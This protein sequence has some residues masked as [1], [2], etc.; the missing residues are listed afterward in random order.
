MHL[1]MHSA[2]N[3]LTASSA[4]HTFSTSFVNAVYVREDRFLSFSISQREPRRTIVPMVSKHLDSSDCP[5]NPLSR[6]TEPRDEFLTKL[7]WLMFS[8][9]MIVTFLLGS[10][11]LIDFKDTSRILGPYLISLYV[12]IGATYA[13]TLIYAFLCRRIKNLVPF[14]YVQIILDLVY[15]TLIVYITGGIDSIF[16]FLYIL[17][18]INASILLYR[19]GG[20]LIASLSSVCYGACI[21]LEYWGILPSLAG[22]SGRVASYQVRD[23]IYMVFI[24]VLAFYATALLSSF[25]AEQLRRSREELK[26]REVDIKELE[27]LHHNIVQSIGS[28]ILTQNQK[29]E[30]TSFNI[31]AQEITGY[32]ARDVLGFRFDEVFPAAA[33]LGDRLQDR[34]YCGPLSR[35]EINFSKPDGT[36]LFLG[37]STSVLRGKTG[38]EMGKILTFRDL[39]AFREMEDRMKRMDRL[40]AVGQLAA[41][42]AHEIRNPLTS[43]S[44]SIQVL[45]DE[46]HLNDENRRLMEIALSET[47]RL[48]GLITD[49]LLFAHPEQGERKSVDAS[50][51]VKETLAL[52]ANSPECRNGLRI[53][54]SI[55][56]SLFVLGDKSQLKQAFWNILRNAAQAQ[57][58]SG[59]IHVDL[60]QALERDDCPPGATG[61][62]V[63]VAFQDGG[64]GIPDDIQKKIFDPFFTTKENGSGLGLAITFRII[65][66][67]QGE[68]GIRSEP[69]H[70]TEVFLFLP[71]FPGH[72]SDTSFDPAGTNSFAPAHSSRRHKAA[73][74]AKENL[75]NAEK[76][77]EAGTR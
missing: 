77:K 69:H 32:E 3:I 55:T 38:N 25:L 4:P 6:S 36:R 64:D 72:A 27:A 22:L 43:L 57:P 31:A 50:S 68:I 42:I 44:G 13:L 10:T 33:A 73:R 76:R 21:T 67:H 46:L 29:G 26:E 14:A 70:G 40:A 58:G 35:F 30:I 8:R 17:S 49:F 66:Q 45:R 41:G 74:V 59:F 63:A 5:A 47:E 54:T 28:G 12:V 24:N 65:E 53:T 75:S 37:F 9:V 34:S 39:T 48:N 51:L 7:N 61:P 2:K 52:F 18:I 56:P 20:L 1:A 19:Q 15:V 60:H 16:S 11:L 71:C 62:W 23:I